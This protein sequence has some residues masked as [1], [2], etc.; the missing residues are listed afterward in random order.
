MKTTLFMAISANGFVARE[1]GNEDFLPHEC[2]LQ[3][4]D[5]AKKY[6]H[7]IWGRKTYEAVM[8][9]GE[10]YIKDIESI[11]IIV[12]CNK[13]SNHYPENVTLCSS[14]KEAIKIIEQMKLKKAFLSGGPTLNTAFIK[15][16]LVDE[17]ILNYNPTILAKGMKLF[18]ESDFELK[19]KLN[20]V[21]E[22]SSDIV[23]LR[24]SIIEILNE[25]STL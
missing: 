25:K 22:L 15:A 7:V 4:L 2:W 23:R 16:N 6:G 20:E 3:F 12:V 24:Y 10:A 13:K 8:E 18:L 5:F 21:K 19:L 17:I 1:D 11:P 9:W 14:P